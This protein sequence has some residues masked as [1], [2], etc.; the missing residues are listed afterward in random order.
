VGLSDKTDFYPEELSG[1]QQQR[2]AIARALAMDPKAMLFD[3]ATSALD[4][5][6]V[7]EVLAVMRRLASQG[8]TMLVVTHEMNFARQVASR[9]VFMDHGKIVEEDAPEQ[10]FGNPREARTRDFLKTIL[11][12]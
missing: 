5:E 8:M 4:P 3:E 1:G 7:S 11:D 6:L 2:A 12:R 9:V 10:I